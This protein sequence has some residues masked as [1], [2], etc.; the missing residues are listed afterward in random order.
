MID[1]YNKRN[2]EHSSASWTLTFV[3]LLSLML[4]FFVLLFSMSTV[5]SAGWDSLVETMSE[6]FSSK[7]AQIAKT[8]EDTKSQTQQSKGL[9]PLYLVGIL[10]SEFKDDPLFQGGHI[11][12]KNRKVIMSI[13]AANLFA[14]LEHTIDA[15]LEKKM[16]GIGI[17]LAQLPN[18]VIIAAY[19]AKTETVS[20]PYRNS[21]EKAIARARS[22]AA[23]VNNRGYNGHMTIVGYNTVTIASDSRIEI[24]ILEKGIE[25]GV[26]GL[27]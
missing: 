7:K 25:R 26:Y 19:T 16:V 13:P 18:S 2:N 20:T 22:V 23:S 17:K 15:E 24:I 27:L 21:R 5:K 3:D 4:T 8:P 12:V 11:S 9:N 1:P 10:K 14:P 6:Q